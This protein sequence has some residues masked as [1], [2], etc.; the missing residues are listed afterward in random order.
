[1]L[2]ALPTKSQKQGKR[3]GNS[4]NCY[5]NSGE[6]IFISLVLSSQCSKSKV[7]TL[8][9]ISR[10]F[11]I[12]SKKEGI[13]RPSQ[14]EI[15]TSIRHVRESEKVLLVLIRNPGKFCLWNPEPGLWNPEYSSWNPESQ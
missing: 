9:F 14:A 1:M 11:D 7:Q 5:I 6:D 10:Y 12:T 13:V 4:L 2:E 15:N 8:T 3:D